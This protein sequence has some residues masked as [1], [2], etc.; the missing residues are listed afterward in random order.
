[1]FIWSR[2]FGKILALS[3]IQY[4]ASNMAPESHVFMAHSTRM[5][6]KIF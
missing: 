4:G 5:I 1:M 6:V 2:A 3:K